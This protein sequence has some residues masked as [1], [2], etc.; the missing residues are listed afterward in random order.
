MGRGRQTGLKRRRLRSPAQRAR[1]RQL[2]ALRQWLRQRG[3]VVAAVLVL[4][5]PF[6]IMGLVGGIRTALGAPPTSSQSRTTFSYT[7][8]DVVIVDS[9]ITVTDDPPSPENRQI[10]AFFTSVGPINNP[11]SARMYVLSGTGPITVAGSGTLNIFHGSDQIATV[12]G[13]G[14]GSGFNA[15]PLIITLGGVVTITDSMVADLMRA[16]AYEDT[17]NDPIS[18]TGPGFRTIELQ[19][20]DSVEGNGPA[21]Q[22]TINSVTQVNDAPT[23]TAPPETLNVD[24]DTD[25]AITT[26]TAST[27]IIISDLDSGGNSIQTT[28]S[29]PPGQGTLTMTGSGCSI[30]GSGTNA[31]TLGA[32]EAAADPCLSTLVYRS[33]PNFSGVVTLS[34]SVND[35]GFSVAGAQNPGQAQSD[36][37][38]I[39]INVTSVNAPPELTVPGG[40]TV[41][42]YQPL[43]I[44]AIGLA[45]ADALSADMQVSLSVTKGVLTIGSQAGLTSVTGDGTASVVL[46][47][48]RAALDNSLDSITYT[49]TASSGNLNDVLTIVANDLGNTGAGGPQSDTE[50]VAITVNELNDPPVITAPASATVTEDVAGDI[51]GISISDPDA[52]PATDPV[53]MTLSVSQ[54]TLTLGNTT[55][56]T[57]TIGDG[58][59]DGTMQFDGTIN[60]INARLDTLTYLTA[61]HATTSATL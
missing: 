46:V 44:P 49:S 2:A 7:E 38:S 14:L 21:M 23:I 39:T 12:P 11:T 40:Q 3:S 42:Q 18:P 47:G 58:T 16:I 24:D 25:L 31:I 20:V 41:L 22:Y 29:V 59:A 10:T 15:G 50:T 48:P 43:A 51:D 34:I 36:S 4:L 33:P 19:I 54:G 1:A 27:P 9:G 28:L 56:L 55:G 60:D 61:L 8:N 30:S 26:P 13:S 57:F 52:N 5:A 6:V 37:D 35:N 53:R 45:D 32:T 17:S